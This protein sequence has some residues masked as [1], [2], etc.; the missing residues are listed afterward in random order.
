MPRTAEGAMDK[1]EPALSG[2]RN[3]IPV[4]LSTRI[5]YRDNLPANFDPASA[6]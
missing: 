2:C 6:R 5:D 4:D 1:T 3:G